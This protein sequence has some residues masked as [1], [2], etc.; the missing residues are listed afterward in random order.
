MEYQ[1]LQKRVY[2]EL[3]GGEQQLVMLARILAQQP[4]ILLLDEP[5]SHLDLNNQYHFIKMI[6][7]FVIEGITIVATMHDPNTAFL[8]G[9]NYLFVHNKK[10]ISEYSGQPWNTPVLSEIYPIKMEKMAV[11]NRFVIFPEGL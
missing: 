4:K 3:S 8:Y 1:H 7:Q 6:K 5:F 2:T 11:R 9:D 10:V